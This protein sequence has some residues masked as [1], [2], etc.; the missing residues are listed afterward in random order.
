MSGTGGAGSGLGGFLKNSTVYAFGNVLNRAGAFLLLPL[1]TR[2]LTVEQYGALELFYVTASVISS[3]LSVGLAHATLRFYFEYKETSERNKVV[4]SCLLS[5]V[6]YA[7]PFVLVLSRWN[8]RLAGLVFGDPSYAPTLN[9]LYATLILELLRQIGLAYFRAREYARMYVAVCFLQLV[10]QVACNVYTVGFQRWGVPGVLWGNLA[11]VAAGC[12]FI[13]FIVIRECGASYDVGKMKAIFRYSYPFLFTA[14]LGVIL[15][16]L[17]RMILRAF[18]SLEAVGLYALAYKFGILVQEL[19]LEPY[20][21]SFGAY[22]FKI[23][24]DP[25][26]RRILS[27]LY[28]YLVA[29]AAF[30]GLGIS[31]F[32]HDVL[33]IMT[34]PAYWEAHRFIPMIALAFVISGASYTFQTG[35]LYSKQTRYMILITATS[36]AVNVFLYLFLIPRFGPMGAAWAVVGK[37]LL[38]A[39][40]TYAI[41]QRLHPVPYDNGKAVKILASAAAVAAAARLL[42][43]LPLPVS[44]PTHAALAALFP[45]LLVAAGCLRR[46]ELA[47]AWRAAGSRLRPRSAEA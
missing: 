7:V 19:L 42:P 37:F 30:M 45:V 12:G 38:E 40:M 44:V 1:Y 31:L 20:N 33:R 46:E 5:T 3:V 6:L 18:F 32:S 21:R 4:T 15:Q 14:I 36:G 13:L 9:V 29:A 23:M 8:G 16:N 10:C 25:D 28:V 2:L 41:S 43:A 47:R 24:N 27:R 22:R 26:S 39:S 35:L 17:D 11:S 34:G